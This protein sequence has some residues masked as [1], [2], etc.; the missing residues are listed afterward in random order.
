MLCTKLRTIFLRLHIFTFFFAHFYVFLHATPWWLRT[1]F[2]PVFVLL[3]IFTFFYTFL[4]FFT[5]DIMMD[6]VGACLGCWVKDTFSLEN[7]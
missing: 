3:H 6:G 1:L 7:M 4:R 5:R 2:E